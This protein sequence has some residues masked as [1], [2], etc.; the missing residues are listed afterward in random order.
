M[1]ATTA[2]PAPKG[3]DA[4]EDEGDPRIARRRR[5]VATARAR[6]RTLRL[7]VVAG[8]VT[9]GALVWGLVQSPLAD[10]DDLTVQGASHVGEDVVR[11]AAGLRV[12]DPLLGTDG[13]VVAGV[14][15]LP[16]IQEASVSR[17]LLAGTVVLEVTERRP[18]AVLVADDGWVLVDEDGVALERVDERPAGE[19]GTG[20][21]TLTVP[22]TSLS[23]VDVPALGAGAGNALRGALDVLDALPPGLATRVDDI[24]VADDQLVLGLRP[25]G[26]VRFGRPEQIGA[27][28]RALQAVL[29]QVDLTD[30]CAVDLRVPASPVVDRS[31]P[32]A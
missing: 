16:W 28:V 3:R 2:P 10:I 23:G 20:D 31:Q 7:G 15:S 32:C 12:G 6:R 30:L 14:E 18:V 17:D 25:T 8:V 13:P 11:E 26:T 21:A 24:A 4:I 9:V 27:K 29:A 5:A 1:S 22:M 19:V